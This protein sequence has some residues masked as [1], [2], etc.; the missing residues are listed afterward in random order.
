[1][2]LI[3]LAV[4]ALV[5]SSGFGEAETCDNGVENLQHVEDEE[6]LWSLVTS[7]YEQDCY[8]QSLAAAL[9]L[10]MVQASDPQVRT[11]SYLILNYKKLG[12]EE[13]KEAVKVEGRDIW[14]P[15][16]LPF[17]KRPFQSLP[18]VQK[19][20]NPEFSAPVPV[21]PALAIEIGLQGSCDVLFDIDVTGRPYNVRSFCS[22]AIFAES[23]ERAVSDAVFLPMI[24]QG[25][26]IERHNVVYPLEYRFSADEEK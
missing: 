25:R 26:P 2:R 15:V 23:A 14:G 4:A 22:D 17:R 9:T 12:D 18:L 7:L 11:Y 1:M 3:Y 8:E 21:Y 19:E 16:R 24:V 10:K 5:A 13:S 6:I 20:D